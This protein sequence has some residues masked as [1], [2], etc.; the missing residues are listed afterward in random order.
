M[1]NCSAPH[2]QWS[3]IVFK[4]GKSRIHPLPVNGF[5]QLQLLDSDFQIEMCKKLLPPFLL[6]DCK[7]KTTHT[8]CSI[9]VITE[10]LQSAL[11]NAKPE[12]WDDE[13]DSE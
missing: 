5:H 4:P 8:N 7:S 13:E 11:C 1:K 6:I 9:K 2:R 10:E 12:D 3:L